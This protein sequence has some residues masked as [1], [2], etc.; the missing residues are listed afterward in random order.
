[1]PKKKKRRVRNKRF[2]TKSDVGTGRDTGLRLRC[3]RPLRDVDSSPTG[4]VASTIQ[5]VGIAKIWRISKA[6]LQLLQ[7]EIEEKTLPFTNIR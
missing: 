4:I 7:N 6:D 2:R 1:M 3:P 5:K